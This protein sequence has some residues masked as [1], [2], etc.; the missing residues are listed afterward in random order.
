[1]KNF[2]LKSAMLIAM[3]MLTSANFK[4][5]A[6][7][8]RIMANP[9]D[10]TPEEVAIRNATSSVDPERER[11]IFAEVEAFLYRSTNEMEFMFN[12]NLGYVTI[13]IVNQYGNVTGSMQCDSATC[14]IVTIN[15]PTA[16]GNYMVIIS[17]N[18]YYGTGDFV[19]Y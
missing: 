8:N 11:S 12:Y 17:G 10:L 2:L 16:F 9:D 14:P 13:Q 7:S 15:T 3:L 18:G 6:N 5:A 19:I 1:M 4:I